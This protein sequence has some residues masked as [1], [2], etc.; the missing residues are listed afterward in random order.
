M[1]A[2]ALTGQHQCAELQHNPNCRVGYELC[3]DMWQAIS[4]AVPLKAI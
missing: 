3:M 1:G 2:S 4:Y